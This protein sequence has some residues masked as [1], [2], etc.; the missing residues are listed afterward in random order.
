MTKKDFSESVRVEQ[1]QQ[2]IAGGSQDP[3]DYSNLADIFLEAGRYDEAVS[4]YQRALKLSRTKL[5]K[6]RL[7]M[8]LG[9][10]F[11]EM[12]RQSE[13]LK[14]GQNSIKL[15]SQEPE[16][17]EV[18]ACRGASQSLLAHCVWFSD[19]KEGAKHARSALGQLEQL[20]AKAPHFEE[21]SSVYYDAARL[22]NLLGNTQETIKLCE[23]CLEYDLC[24]Q[25]R[26]SCL[27]VYVEALRRE[28]RFAEA[29]PLLN[30]VLQHTEVN[31]G[32]SANLYFSLGLIQQSMNRL[33]EARESLQKALEALQVDPYLH[34]DTYFLTQIHWNLGQIYFRQGEYEKAAEIFQKALAS[35]P[36]D[37]PIYCNAVL[38]LGH[39]YGAVGD[40]IHARDCYEKLLASPHASD[41][42]RISARKGLVRSIADIFYQSGKH[43]D[44]A[45][46]FERALNYY[47]KDDPCRPKML[48][49]LGHC[50]LITGDSQKARECYDEV[51]ASAQ[52]LEEDKDSARKNLGWSLGKL[53]YES[54]DYSNATAAFKEILTYHAK[55][56]SYY[57]RALLWLGYAYQGKGDIDKARECYEDILALA[58]ASPDEKASALDGLSRLPVTLKNTLH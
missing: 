21:M 41:T 30:E 48:L 46:A 53:Y 34:E 22:Q 35:C 14:L 57:S 40:Y 49:S 6:A 26:L 45:G 56:D 31:K 37:D 16:S 29:E 9:W 13:A 7:S 10:L 44:A 25:E 5:Q 2:K 17:A 1:L 27:T 3:D 50:Y 28:E 42:D 4:S 15:L 38:W 51:L 54:G 39:S 52:A 20:V 8:E 24:E 36:Q 55:N 19:E 47:T 11:Y 23:K 32:A 12:G 43:R 33:M 58:N 18:L